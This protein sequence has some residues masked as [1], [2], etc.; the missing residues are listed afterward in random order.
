MRYRRRK[1]A[2]IE[3]FQMTKE[4]RADNRDWPEW[5]N[6]AWNK[7]STAHGAVWPSGPRTDKGYLVADTPE[8]S[9]TVGWDWWIVF[10]VATGE[11]QVM[12]PERFEA[13][14]EPV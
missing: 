9:L 3:A 12:S 5:L 2:E 4:R 8:G 13:N 14:Y 6:K 7:P 11:L 10:V 1:P